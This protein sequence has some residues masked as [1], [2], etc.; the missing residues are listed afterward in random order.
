LIT[1]ENTDDWKKNYILTRY[2]PKEEIELFL[3][4]V[5]TYSG[6]C[7]QA[8]RFNVF[9]FFIQKATTKQKQQNSSKM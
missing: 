9:S 1:A 4:I 6:K 5:V 3:Y 8:K 7:S 2:E